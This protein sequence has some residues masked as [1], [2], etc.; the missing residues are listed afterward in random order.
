MKKL[1]ITLLKVGISVAIIAW[2]VY[3]A[4]AKD[5]KVFANLWHQPKDW[6]VLLAAWAFCAAAVMLTLI[7][8][9]YLVRALDIPF[10]FRD[11]FRIGLLG[12]LFNLAPMGIVGGDL[13]KAFMLARERR[14]H[15]AKAVASVAVDRMIGLYMLFVVASVAIL[16]TGFDDMPVAKIQMICKATFL[17]AAVGTAG[18][19]I[20]L[21]PTLTEGRMARALGRLPR[22]GRLIDSLIEPLRMY[23]RKIHVL[24]GACFFSV[25]VH[26]LFAVG[27]Y[28]IARGLPGQ[29]LSLA[30]HFVMSPLSA[31]TGVLPLPMGPFEAVLEFLYRHVSAVEGVVIAPG[32]GL[33]VALGYR[34]ITVLIAMVGFC[35]YLSAR[36]EIAEVMHEAE[37]GQPLDDDAPTSET[38]TQQG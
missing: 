4:K 29:V 12:Y 17:I 27:I 33:V 11:A 8:W 35:Y 24:L 9:C 1:L 19:V 32:Q 15:R 13:L 2:L 36:R 30:K 26:S 6:A 7:R 10:M 31:A 25:G 23:R 5:E 16:L 18:L 3:D 20:L 34:I 22:V 28:L 37:L 14:G 21:I 38:V